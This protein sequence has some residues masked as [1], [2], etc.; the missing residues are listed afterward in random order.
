MRLAPINGFPPLVSYPQSKRSVYLN[1]VG[2]RLR[3]YSCARSPVAAGGGLG[4]EAAE[5]AGGVGA[6]A[7]GDGEV[8]KEAAEVGGLFDGEGLGRANA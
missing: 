5:A 2:R 4:D 1:P 3:T 8:V 6:E 7:D